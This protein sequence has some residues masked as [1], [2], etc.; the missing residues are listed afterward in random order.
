MIDTQE[1]NRMRWASRRGMLELDLVL[2]PFVENKYATLNAADR[3]SFQR[4]MASE[5]QELFTWFLRR[6]EP[7]DLELKAIVQQILTFTRSDSNT[8]KI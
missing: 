3:L 6:E 8:A 2:G 4:L 7:N 1:L 5:D